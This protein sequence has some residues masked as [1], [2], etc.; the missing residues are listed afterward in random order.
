MP[1]DTK[2]KKIPQDR[3]R[4]RKKPTVIT[5]DIVADAEVAAEWSALSEKVQ[6]C[7]LFMS[8]SP[9][10]EEALA[11]SE[12]VAALDQFEADNEGFVMKFRFRAIG[13][14]NYEDLL[15]AHAPTEE[16]IAQAVKD[17]GEEAGKNLE[18]NPDTFPQ[19]LVAASM[20]QDEMDHDEMIAWLDSDA[21]NH[22]ELV[23]LFQG[24]YMANTA[25]RVVELGKR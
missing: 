17:H 9:G 18:F 5:V 11:L 15:K 16:Q 24:A 7:K 8:A 14:D 21:W 2:S 13:R 19:E 3:L 4:S 1:Q 20:I 6:D 23:D 10:A 12:A 22:K 25:R